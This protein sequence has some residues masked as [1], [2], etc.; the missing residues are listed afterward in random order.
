[1]IILITTSLSSNTY[2]KLLDARIGHLKEQNQCFPLH[3]SSFEIYDACE[4][5]YQVALIDLKYEKI[6]R[7]RKLDPIAIKP[8]NLSPVSREI[9]SDSV[10]EL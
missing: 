5:H 7:D 9:I 10:V 1:M 2:K 4:H 3:R 8:S 6:S